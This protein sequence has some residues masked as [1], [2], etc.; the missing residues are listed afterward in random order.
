MDVVTVHSF[1]RRTPSRVPES[2]ANRILYVIF[3][4]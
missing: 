2:K 1:C 4:I 3:V